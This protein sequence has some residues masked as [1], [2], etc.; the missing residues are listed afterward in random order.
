MRI[1]LILDISFKIKNNTIRLRQLKFNEHGRIG[2]IFDMS[3]G[4][5]PH[6]VDLK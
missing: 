3:S 6:T 1:G 5:E 2:L 4:I